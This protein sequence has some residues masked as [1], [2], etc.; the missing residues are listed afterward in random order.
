MNTGSIKINIERGKTPSIEIQLV[1]NN[2]WLC[3][4]SIA[5]LFDCFPQKI[6]M[7]LRSIFKQRLLVEDKVTYSYRYTDKG[8]DKEAIYY[9]LEMLIFLSYRIDTFEAQI[10]Y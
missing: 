7:N 9:N 10:F 8:I 1:D 5:Q 2:L 3:K 4:Y 6:E